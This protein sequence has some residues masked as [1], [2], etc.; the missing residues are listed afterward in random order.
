MM[1][2]ASAI[3]TNIN[4]TEITL[5]KINK[6]VDAGAFGLFMIVPIKLQEPESETSVVSLI[7]RYI[8]TLQGDLSVKFIAS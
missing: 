6:A 1:N 8:L 4:I 3:E 5:V 2:T 7:A